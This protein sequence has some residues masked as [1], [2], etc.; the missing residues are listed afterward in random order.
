M[1][2]DMNYLPPP[3]ELSRKL[4]F[5]FSE[6]QKLGEKELLTE[7]QKEDRKAHLMMMDHFVI[8]SYQVNSR[9]MYDIALIRT[10]R[11]ALFSNDTSPVHAAFVILFSK[12]ERNFYLNS[13]MWLMDSCQGEDFEKEWK[14]APNAIELKKIITS[15]LSGLSTKKTK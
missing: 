14:S 5:S 10:R 9:D 7:F 2:I 11:G 13:L 6:R 3:D 1:V 8:L 12:D 4:A 15:R